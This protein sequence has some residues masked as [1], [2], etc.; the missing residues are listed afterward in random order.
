MGQGMVKASGIEPVP[1]V[2]AVETPTTKL[3]RRYERVLERAAHRGG[4]K[5][6]FFRTGALIAKQRAA[7]VA[8]TVTG[9]SVPEIAEMLGM[10]PAAVWQAR[11][12]M[13]RQGELRETGDQ[14]DYGLVPAA[15][16]KLEALIEAGDKD[17][18]LAVLR[19]RGA[20][21]VHQSQPPAAGPAVMTNLV[22][23]FAMPP[24]GV[25]P[26]LAGQVVGVRRDAEG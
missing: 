1:E 11:Y 14:L 20:F 16:A 10:Q 17:A 4:V 3:A 18:I 15:V 26:I 2:E 22:V 23:T 6:M 9:Y 25:K 19:G 5:R 21:K 12:R 24:G 13:R 7:I 8:M